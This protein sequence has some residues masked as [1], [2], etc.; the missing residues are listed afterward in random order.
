MML[1]S[2]RRRAHLVGGLMRLEDVR[3]LIAFDDELSDEAARRP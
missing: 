2:V 3:L 1:M